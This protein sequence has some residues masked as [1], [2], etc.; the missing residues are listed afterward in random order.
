MGPTG[1]TIWLTGLSGSGKSTLARALGIR[2]R[3]VG[4]Q[5]TI[6]DGEEIRKQFSPGLGFCKQDRDDHIQR[7]GDLAKQLCRNENPVIVAAISPY[8][9]GR[10]KNRQ[11]IEKFVEVYC[12]CPID[13]AERRD[14]KGLYQKARNGEIASFTGIDD[15]YEEPLSAEVVVDTDVETVDESLEKIWTVLQQLGYAKARTRVAD[16]SNVLARRTPGSGQ[17]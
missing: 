2:F 6:L 1:V 3:T 11:E 16:T 7:I 15:P 14:V 9:S 10:D 8:R 12:R 4:V 17:N 13:V 5:A